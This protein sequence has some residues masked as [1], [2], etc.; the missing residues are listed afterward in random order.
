MT[1]SASMAKSAVG[2]A[3]LGAVW[4]TAWSPSAQ[5]APAAGSR[6]RV[7]V[8]FEAGFPAIDVEVIPEAALR[9]ALAG[10]DIQLLSAGRLSSDLTRDRYDTLVLP[11][12]SAYPEVA[13]PAILRFLEGGG[14][15][16]NVGGRPFAVAVSRRGSA[17]QAQPESSACYKALG[18][19][20]IFQVPA[21]AVRTWSTADSAPA[22]PTSLAT[23][24]RADAVFEAD[25]RLTNTKDFPDEDGSDGP[26]EGR[27]QPLVIGKDAAGTPIAAPIVRIDRLVG[28]FSGGAWVLANLRGSVSP[29]AVRTLVEAASSGA[30]EIT[31]RP[32]LAGYVAGE[33]PEIEVTVRRPGAS[34][35]EPRLLEA[36]LAFTGPDGQSLGTRG[37][38]ATG[39]AALSSVRVGSSGL[40]RP[41]GRG[42]HEVRVSV[43]VRAPG[44]GTTA[45]H[46]ETRTGFWVY[47]PS[48][49][50]GGTPLVASKDGFARNGR[51]F[52]VLGTTYMASDVHR[53]FLLEPNPA[54]WN[55]DF[56]QMKAAGVNLV[57]TGIWTGWTRY[58]PE[59]GRLD[60]S[61]L[62]ALDI[63]LLTARKYDIPVIFNFF[64]FLPEAWGGENPFL[65]ARAV[66]AQQAFLGAIARRYPATNDVVWDL[67]NEPSFS[68]ASQLWRTRPN[69]D[70]SENAAWKQWLSTRYGAGDEDYRAAALRAWGA[71]PDEG[72]SLPS[73]DDFT[74]R[75]LF[76]PGRPRKAADY[77][78]FSQDMF[79]AWVRQM[80]D[81]LRSNGNRAQLVTVG[82]DEG[83]LSERPNPL[84]F[85]RSVDFT[86]M[87][88]WWNNDAQAWD[89]VLSALPDRP[90][91]VEETGM[92]RYERVDG[93]P[94][95]TEQDA[96]SLLERK[97]A[98]AV[99]S[100]S[101]G[102]VQWIWN[103]NP[104][105]ASDNEAG[106]GFLRADGTARPEL[107]PFV[108]LS[109]FLRMHADRLKGRQLEDVALLIPHSQMFSPRSQ[110]VEATQRAVRILANHLHVP[111]RAVGEYGLADTLGA[112]R[113]IIAPSPRVLTD[114]AWQALLAAVEKGSTLLVTGIIDADEHWLPVERTQGLGLRASS[115]PVAGQE[116]V[117]IAGTTYRLGYRGDRLERIETAFVAGESPAAVRR[118]VRGKGTILW[119]PLPVELSDSPD[120]T[121]AL[122]RA[123]IT[124]A[125]VSPAI[126]VEPADGSVYVGANSYADAVLVALASESSEDRDVSVSLPGGVVTRLRLP[127]GRA[128]LLL[129]DR[130]SG[131]VLGS[132]R[133][134]VVGSR[135]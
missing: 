89:A 99:G 29:A 26:R 3:V 49:L 81:A 110:A 70:A 47:D 64:A 91:L 119:M 63:F 31:A 128:M 133:D 126:V 66:A 122:Y 28:R 46:L 85:G 17:W 115:R 2:A 42:L 51:P 19:T 40:D 132:D 103:T 130:K 27:V 72:T 100:G 124:Q 37:A 9:E 12:G 7:A 55:R 87:H 35:D 106:I 96:A 36:T 109:R 73:L 102:Y 68:A 104:F 114:V 45:R 116:P 97:L 62:R 74:D 71:A 77:K 56:A 118:V 1:H 131:K 101:S 53:R 113:L 75:N 135:Q 25:I 34:P 92:M 44:S 23:G 82:Q 86:C 120:A 39:T 123:A 4:L 90:M 54:L 11:F 22:V 67:I 117:V 88:T 84:F 13:W 38:T 41:L 32:T 8:F 95:R 18:F 30:I 60:E 33:V 107:E 16:V 76:G 61:A 59:V 127:A 52:P 121:V 112:P 21:A 129:V 108:R 94:W 83:G 57:R 10:L 58:M 93:T 105:M 78:R 125:G 15:L 48:M 111:A 5:S 98:M 6:P 43:E 14:N 20:H 80:T 69:G 134:G 65:D 79:T 50:H 24:F